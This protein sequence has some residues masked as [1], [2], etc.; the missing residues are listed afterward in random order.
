MSDIARDPFYQGEFL[1]RRRCEQRPISIGQLLHIKPNHLPPSAFDRLLAQ[2]KASYDRDEVTWICT[3]CGRVVEPLALDNGGFLYQSSCICQKKL[4]EQQR[5]EA[6]K[7]RQRLQEIQQRRQEQLKKITMDSCFTWLGP[8]FSEEGLHKLTFDN[9]IPAQAKS[10]HDD[11]EYAKARCQAFAEM[12]QGTL[13]LYGPCGTGKTHLACGIINYRRLCLMQPALFTTAPNLIRAIEARRE[14]DRGIQDIIQMIVSA[15]LLVID[16]IE[17]VGF[18]T[19]RASFWLDLMNKRSNRELNVPGS[20]PTVFTTN[21]SVQRNASELG[22]FVGEAAA[23]RMN[24]GL[25]LVN[26]PGDDYREQMIAE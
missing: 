7:Q 24:I 26:V 22:E 5:I 8:D 12:P 3:V 11:L 15:P 10:H 21:V 6:D 13:I 20:A 18:T 19:W 16:D 23:S 25:L 14:Q 1:R 9:Y 17:K 4:V 2:G